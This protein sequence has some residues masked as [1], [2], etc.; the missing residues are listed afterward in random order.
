MPLVE[1]HRY[2]DAL[3]K[4]KEK[5]ASLKPQEIAAFKKIIWNEDKTKITLSF[6][7]ELYEIT[8]PE[9]KISK[10]EGEGH[11]GSPLK[12]L[13]LHYLTGGYIPLKEEWITFRSFPGGEEYFVPF[14]ARALRPLVRLFGDDPLAFLKAGEKLGGRP[15]NLGDA[16]LI[17]YPFADIPLV[18]VFW[19][20]E[21]EFAPE[22]N[23]LFDASAPYFLPTE[24]FVVLGELMV[25][26]FKKALS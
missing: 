24:D 3:L 7:N 4:G 21:E 23:L 11:V 8:Y 25:S 19:K 12:I 18:Y 16:G 2:K 6:L 13:I 20:G 26:Y 14:R 17:L 5:L 9:G 15:Y 22:I 1:E 10:K